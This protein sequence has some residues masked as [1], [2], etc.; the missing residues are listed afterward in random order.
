V[1]LFCYPEPDTTLALPLP[2]LCAT[3]RG[4]PTIPRLAARLTVGKAPWELIETDRKA[5]HPPVNLTLTVTNVGTAN[6]FL[7][8][9]AVTLTLHF[10]RPG[11]DEVDARDFDGYESENS[12]VGEGKG[13]TEK[14]K[15]RDGGMPGTAIGPGPGEE[16]TVMGVGME[17]GMRCSL[18]RA[19]TLE[20]R[21]FQLMVGETARFG[22]I[23]IP[24]DGATRVWGAWSIR[25]QGGF[26]TVTGDIAPTTLTAAGRQDDEE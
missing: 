22:P 13:K 5:V 24:A 1:I 15:E 17:A 10:D 3:L 20:A 14:E 9:D 4:Q 7:A 18:P 12:G 11:L 2:T 19:N 21:K 26:E 8:A 23:R 6:T 16:R 25:R